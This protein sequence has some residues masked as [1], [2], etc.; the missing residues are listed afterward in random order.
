MRLVDMSLVQSSADFDAGGASHP[1]H[2]L[3]YVLTPG[4]SVTVGGKTFD[5]S[6]GDVFIYPARTPHRPEVR[7]DLTVRIY[8]VQWREAG[9]SSRSSHPLR[10]SRLKRVYPLHVRDQAGRLLAS[11]T[12]MWEAYPPRAAGDRRLLHSLLVAILE[13]VKRLAARPAMTLAERVTHYMRQDMARPLALKELAAA[14]RVSVY[15]LIRAFRR[16]TGETPGRRLQRMRVE[17][18]VNLLTSTSEPLKTIAR[19]VGYSSAAHMG[20]LVRRLTGRTP[21]D[22]RRSHSLRAGR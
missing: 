18:A 8:V 11:L 14:E 22:F 21:G 6:P 13:E 1:V 10:S 3:I 9:H 20:H 17:R 2:E 16:E 4:Y 15:H 5:A 12:W 7:R 19:A